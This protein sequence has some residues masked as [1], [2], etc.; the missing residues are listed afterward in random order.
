MAYDESF[1]DTEAEKTAIVEEDAAEARSLRTEEEAELAAEAEISRRE[2]FARV[3]L[4]GDPTELGHMHQL[5]G[6]SVRVVFGTVAAAKAWMTAAGLTGIDEQYDRIN[7]TYDDGVARRNFSAYP[8]WFGWTLYV[9]ADEPVDAQPPDL[10]EE[11]SSRL[12]EIA[13]GT[14]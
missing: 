4:L 7:N 3:L 13:G 10:T 9:R 12:R 8:V 11:T 5:D 2:L 14:Q 6:R 1:V